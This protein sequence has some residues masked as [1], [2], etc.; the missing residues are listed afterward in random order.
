MPKYAKTF[1][2]DTEI[3]DDEREQDLNNNMPP[4]DQLNGEEKTWK[5]RYGDLRSHTQRQ[6]NDLQSQIESLKT[7]VASATNNKFDLPT[8]EEE[9]EAWTK[10]Y[11][12]IAAIVTTIARTNARQVE[13]NLDGRIQRL[14]EREAANDKREAQS[15]L[16]RLHP[17]FFDEIKD[18]EDFHTWLMGKSKRTQDSIYEN[19]LD[20]EW[21]ADTITL[22]K[23]ETNWGGSKPA[24]RRQADPRDGAREV[25]NSGRVQPSTGT[26]PLFSESQ[27]E[28][29]SG[30]EYAKNEEAIDKAI[31]EGRFVYDLTAA[32]DARNAARG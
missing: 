27:V 31:K 16:A 6:V 28:R 29:M 9:V 3:E 12:R 26:E 22:F 5:K 8:T 23:R 30:A 32:A 7:Q 11:P 4:D 13:E 15:Q 19:D 14:Q 21:A 17:D 10:K 25:R 2:P 20:Y 24:P 18:N 1:A